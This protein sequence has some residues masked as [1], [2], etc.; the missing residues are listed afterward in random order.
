[1]K[2]KTLSNLYQLSA[3]FTTLTENSKANYRS[4]IKKLVALEPFVVDWYQSIIAQSTKNSSKVLLLSILRTV[5]GWGVR[6]GVVGTDPTLQFPRRKLPVARSTGFYRKEE[7]EK[8]WG[9]EKT[10]YTAALRIMFYTGCRPSEVINLT[11]GDVDK[12]LIRIVG[13]KRKEKGAVS[14][15]CKVTPQIQECLQFANSVASITGRHEPLLQVT[16][17]KKIHR[18]YWGSQIRKVLQEL[19]MEA[20]ELR[21]ARSGLATAM[22]KAGYDI[23]QIKNQLGHSSVATTERYIRTTM[24]EK[25]LAFEGV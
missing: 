24:E 25:A 10:V 7:I 20:R 15:Y 14:R 21:H 8:V 17:G 3:D 18:G 4:Q 6:T 9:H 12:G 1:M 11:M 13:A 2:F 16:H 5:Y 22:Q 19:C 23:Y